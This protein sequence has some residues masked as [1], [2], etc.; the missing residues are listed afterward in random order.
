MGA[1]C[2]DNSLRHKPEQH[3]DNIALTPPWLLAR[4]RADVFASGIDLDP[5]TESSNPTDARRFIALPDDG[6]LMPWAGP[7][8]WVN[9]PYGSTLGMW[10]EKCALVSSGGAIECCSWFQLAPR[11]VGSSEPC[12]CATTYCYFRSGFRFSDTA[13]ARLRMRRFRVRCLRS[14]CSLWR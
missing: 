2:W 9:P 12:F 1:T 3:V 13:D 11:R 6:I 5:A 7:N 14:A 10:V 4:I 8:I